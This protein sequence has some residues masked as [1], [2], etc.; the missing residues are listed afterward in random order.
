MTDVLNRWRARGDACGTSVRPLAARDDEARGGGETREAAR[1][2]PL[3]ELVARGGVGGAAGER[4]AGQRDDRNAGLEFGGDFGPPRGVEPPHH[5]A[6]GLQRGDD[7]LDVGGEIGHRPRIA[8]AAERIESLAGDA[9]VHGGMVGARALNTIVIARDTKQRT[10]ERG[11]AVFRLP[12]L[13]RQ[14]VTGGALPH[15][16]RRR[17]GG[18]SGWT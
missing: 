2:G 5:F 6:L 17:R 15:H 16:R 8:I 14:N 18:R 10:A 13:A 12:A 11:P 4:A 9:G 7:T 1:A 3:I